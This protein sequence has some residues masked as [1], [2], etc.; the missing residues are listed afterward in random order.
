[1]SAF[2]DIASI[3]EQVATSAGYAGPAVVMAA[4]EV[5]PIPSEVVL[6]LVGAQVS[7]GQLLFW[8]ATL[9][10]TLGSVL[11]AWA[12]YAVGRWGGRPAV[13]RLSRL[14]GVREERMSRAESWFTRHGTVVVLVSRVVPGLRG[15][16][17]VPAGTLRMPMA[18]FLA[19]TAVGAFCWNA[20]LIGGGLL[21]ADRWRSVLDAA[22]GAA[23]YL[24]LAAAVA[25]LLWTS[26]RARFRAARP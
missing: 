24:L 12:L 21:L 17:S 4:G 20:S 5:L 16:A 25:A 26:Q 9:A 1:M 6:P 3:A 10:A 13:L 7:A 8:A 14:L 18:R 15:L 11:G 23:P 19:L 2:A 22:A